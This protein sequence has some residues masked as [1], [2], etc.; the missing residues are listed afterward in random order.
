MRL[1][2]SD[3]PVLAIL[4]PSRQSCPQTSKK[5]ELRWDGNKRVKLIKSF[6]AKKMFKRKKNIQQRWVKLFYVCIYTYLYI[7]NWL[8]YPQPPSANGFSKTN[9]TYPLQQENAWDTSTRLPCKRWALSKNSP[10][11]K[12]TKEGQDRPF[13]RKQVFEND[14]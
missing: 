7:R 2:T 12:N 9:I 10:P 11:I 3:P 5:N 14:E 1:L 6:K 4:D 13:S 8:H